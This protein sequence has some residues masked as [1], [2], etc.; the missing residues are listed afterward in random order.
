MFAVFVRQGICPPHDLSDLLNALRHRTPRIHVEETVV[1]T[2][3]LVTNAQ[4]PLI[5]HVLDMLH[6]NG[7]IAS[8]A[9][10]TL[11]RVQH[12]IERSERVVQMMLG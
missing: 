7:L 4:T 6:A 10:H 5:D 2:P 12:I 1:P 9:T 11:E 8:D 3:Y